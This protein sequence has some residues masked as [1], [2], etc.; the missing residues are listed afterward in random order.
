MPQR[1]AS[2][3]P[4]T[5]RRLRFSSFLLKIT[6]C[7]SNFSRCVNAEIQIY[8]ISEMSSV[9]DYL[10]ND[11]S[12]ISRFQAAAN[13]E[14]LL[15]NSNIPSLLANSNF[16]DSLEC[17]LDFERT[18]CLE[19]CGNVSTTFANWPNFYTCSWYPEISAALNE[20]NI[21][22]S[23]LERLDA[24]GISANQQEFS[25]N[26][27]ST[28]GNCLAD[29]C[30][31]SEQCQDSDIYDSCDSK[32]LFLDN[33]LSKTLNRTAA[34]ECVRYGVCGSTAEINPDIGGL[35]VSLE[36][37]CILFHGL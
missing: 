16:T 31:Y 19:V 29:F 8:R 33:G 20:A 6:S 1:C 26:I 17:K 22:G 2:N 15:P 21:T 9:I 3:Q 23:G 10:G 13:L 36:V 11:S 25:L 5:C 14:F 37:Q 7:A 34:V 24:I 30:Q 32:S 12:S 27:S 28:I 18:S 4:P 35:G